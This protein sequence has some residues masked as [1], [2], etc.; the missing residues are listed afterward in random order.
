MQDGDILSLIAGIDYRDALRDIA[1]D[2]SLIVVPHTFSD[3]QSSVITA[4]ILKKR[5]S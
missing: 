2:G 3:A 5:K 1:K 4:E